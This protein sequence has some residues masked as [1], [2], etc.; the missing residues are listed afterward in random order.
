MKPWAT[1]AIPVLRPGDTLER[2]LQ[3][4]RTSISALPPSSGSQVFGPP[5]ILL[6]DD[7]ENPQLDEL[8]GR[9]RGRVVRH[10]STQG[11]AAA[12]NTAL[13]NA[14]GEVVI[15]LDSDT[16]PV[17]DWLLRLRAH[18]E[19][20]PPRLGGV[21]GQALEV[22]RRN[23][24]ER[25]NALFAPQSHGPKPREEDWMLM[26]LVSSYRKEALQSI[27]GF[28]SLFRTNAEDIDVGLRLRQK[29]WQLR[30]DPELVVLHD[31]AH[32]PRSFRDQVRRYFYWR[33]VALAKNG[34]STWSS[35]FYRPAKV[36]LVDLLG[37][38]RKDL[39]ISDVLLTLLVFYLRLAGAISALSDTRRGLLHLEVTR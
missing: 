26:G 11:V 23:S 29:G 6:V 27:G 37:C 18:Y 38:F 7:G 30:Y 35:C 16:I 32:G 15:F 39:R 8:A 24:W 36:M 12:R 28:D 5:E 10:P 3:T 19:D 31:K 14:R 25:W 21:G 13:A 34:C 33:L 17:G 22:R 2:T 20:A 1:I 4:V 9:H